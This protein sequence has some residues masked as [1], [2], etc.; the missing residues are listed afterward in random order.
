MWGMLNSVTFKVLSAFFPPRP[1]HLIR[2]LAHRSNRS[3]ISIS[4]R[5]VHVVFVFLIFTVRNFLWG[6][7]LWLHQYSWWAVLFTCYSKA[8]LISFT[9]ANMYISLLRC[10][11]L[12]LLFWR[13]EVLKRIKRN[14]QI[15]TGGKKTTQ[16]LWAIAS[17]YF[18]GMTAAWNRSS[19]QENKT[20]KTGRN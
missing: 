4:Y 18:G 2:F 5:E 14:S 12:L 11:F 13:L 9:K 10:F 6:L 19:N 7:W 8:T 1:R 17:F 3:G 15:R 16:L 20:H